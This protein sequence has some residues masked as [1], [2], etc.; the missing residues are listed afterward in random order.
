MSE[1]E[2]Q[3]M[4]RRMLT[5][6]AFAKLVKVTTDVTMTVVCTYLRFC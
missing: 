1:C 3:S 2:V 6:I 4:S 5:P